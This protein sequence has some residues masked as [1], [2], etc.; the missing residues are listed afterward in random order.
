MFAEES[1]MSAKDE[2]QAKTILTFRIRTLIGQNI[3]SQFIGGRL[4]V[5]KQ[6]TSLR[7][8][9]DF[10]RHVGHLSEIPYEL[11]SD[12]MYLSSQVSSVH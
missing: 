1:E 5:H 3:V 4:I 6:Q 10:V 11:F 12:F 2:C 7:K 9:Q 8:R